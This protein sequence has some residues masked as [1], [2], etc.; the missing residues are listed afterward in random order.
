MCLVTF[1]RGTDPD[2]GVPKEAGPRPMSGAP[3]EQAR[4]QRNALEAE[5]KRI[6]RQ[7]RQRYREQQTKAYE[8]REHPKRE[9]SQ[10]GRAAKLPS[11]FKD[12]ESSPGNQ[13][14]TTSSGPTRKAVTFAIPPGDSG[15]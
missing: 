13:A 11:R 7:R 12:G 10:L 8:N 5:R 9:S 3:A 2:A 15:S 1:T 14:G 6:D 4:Q